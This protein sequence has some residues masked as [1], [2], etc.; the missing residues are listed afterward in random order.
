MSRAEASDLLGCR[1]PTWG[2]VTV[3][4][5]AALVLPKRFSDELRRTA[6]CYEVT[7]F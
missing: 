7:E 2:S 5:G 1:V 3:F 6:A 4:A